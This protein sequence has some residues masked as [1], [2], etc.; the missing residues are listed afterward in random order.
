MKVSDKK[1]IGK[2]ERISVSASSPIS[3]GFTP[4]TEDAE[5]VAVRASVRTQNASA[6]GG[7]CKV[8]ACAL[9]TVVLK[10]DDGFCQE[11]N[12]VAFDV[13][14]KNERIADDLPIGVCY[15]VGDVKYSSGSGEYVISAII[16]SE[17]DFYVTTEQEYI[18]CREGA[19]VKTE[20]I[21]ALARV[22]DFESVFDDGG[23]KEFSF[24]I[25]AMLCREERVR[26]KSVACGIDHVNVGGEIV[27]EFLF[28]TPRG[29]FVRESLTVPFTAEAECE[30]CTPD[31]FAVAFADVRAAN[32]R[33]ENDGE[34]KHSTLSGEFTLGFYISV[35]RSETH[36]IIADA[37]SA[38]EELLL[39]KG[40]LGY[41]CGAGNRELGYKCFGEAAS[42]KGDGHA[43]CVLGGEVY[44]FDYA[45]EGGKL[46]LSG[47]VRA[48]ILVR[49]KDE[50]LRKAY[51]ELP[52]ACSFDY[53][54]E[55]AAVDCNPIGIRAKELDGKCVLECELAIG[56]R[57]VRY[58]GTVAVTE[59]EAGEE[60]KPDDCAV[61]IV[62][63]EKGDD[64]WT[65]CKK[66]C[67]SQD[68]LF[69]LNPELTFP[70]EKDSGIVVYRKLGAL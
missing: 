26:V 43:V 67:I 66:A 13:A 7:E 38:K 55:P 39:A 17:A 21:E 57:F 28:A 8:S 12:S 40:E 22:A 48:D 2:V 23:D 15:S 60:R 65:V 24:E 19:T 42:D 3:Y 53:D 61:R 31:D 62:F 32:Y 44:A 50:T 69:K 45:K 47:V 64:A 16:D 30:N 35:F 25:A 68:E 56:T 1:K 36:T 49:D 33:V 29:E 51:A 5:I 34:K 59:I 4:Q 11:E 70:A 52:F 9:F 6:S 20:E 37:F 41:V 14:F 18:D 63:V 54:G 10:G 58:T 27:A 46:N